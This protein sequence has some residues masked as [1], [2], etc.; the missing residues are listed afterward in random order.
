MVPTV[1]DFIQ[2]STC[3]LNRGNLVIARKEIIDDVIKALKKY[4]FLYQNN[5]FLN[6]E[7]LREAL[8]NELIDIRDQGNVDRPYSFVSFFIWNNFEAFVRQNFPE[9]SGLEIQLLLHC[10]QRFP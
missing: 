6:V 5:R 3:D 8:L 10:H 1:V 2:Y 9:L 7:G 4:F